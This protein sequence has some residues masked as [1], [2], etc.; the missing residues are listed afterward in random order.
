MAL[1]TDEK[2]RRAMVRALAAA[3]KMVEVEDTDPNDEVPYAGAVKVK[4]AG[5][6]NTT[7][8]PT[9]TFERIGINDEVAFRIFRQ[10]LLEDQG[11]PA[12]VVQNLR[13]NESFMGLQPSVVVG[14]VYQLV[15][16]ELDN[17]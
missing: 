6:L 9:W 10:S 16:R 5:L 17:A 11:L 12:S 14:L 7:V 4:P 13:E 3:T 2:A 15:L 1:D 8:S